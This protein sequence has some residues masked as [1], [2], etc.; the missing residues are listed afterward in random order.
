MRKSQLQTATPRRGAAAW[1][2]AGLLLL[3]PLASTAQQELRDSAG[4]RLGWHFSLQYGAPRIVLLPHQPGDS[5][6][7]KAIARKL[8]HLRCNVYIP[9]LPDL[10]FNPHAAPDS[11]LKLLHR[12]VTDIT[13]HD[14]PSS[15]LLVGA[16]RSAALAMMAATT[17]FRVK[18]VIAISPGEYFDPPNAVQRVVGRLRVPLLVLYAP[19]EST[20]MRTLCLQVP[21]ELIIFSPTLHH[22]GYQTLL[23]DQPE[24][25]PAWLAISIFYSEQFGR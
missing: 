15:V 22:A 7:R 3:A 17:D 21:K 9:E 1:I 2:C 19:H 18:Q 6:I 12:V 24:S 25:G 23:L 13:R 10:Y 16:G 5:N 8:L 20:T 11:L 14:E 4:H